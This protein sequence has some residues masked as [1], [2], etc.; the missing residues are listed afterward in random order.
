MKK[1]LSV[2]LVLSLM[3][4]A[5]WLVSCGD[6]KE[7]SAKT[8]AENTP[9]ETPDTT[10]DENKEET[11]DQ[12]VEEPT[13]PDVIT[14]DEQV[15]YD[16]DGVVIT[17]KG[18]AED[19]LFGTTLKLLIENNSDK[20]ISVGVDSMILNGFEM[21]PLFAE[22]VA[23]G[24]KANAEL[25]LSFEELEK[26]GIKT[27]GLIELV[28]EIYDPE[29]YDTYALSDL[30]AV[31]TNAYEVM[32]TEITAEGTELYNANGIKVVTLGM[33]DTILGKSI[34]LYIENTSDKN[35]TLG[36]DS[37]SLNGFMIEPLF[38]EDV[39]AGKKVI[40]S[41][42]IA[43][44]DLEDNGIE[45]IENIEFVLSITDAETWETIATSDP[46]VLGME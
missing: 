19:I 11:P 12:K 43:T 39:S 16:N 18:L 29:T 6:N 30:V 41:I 31:K 24:K 40:G 8:P 22:D 45:N 46:I 17:A 36:T 21:F 10:P 44:S 27:L 33:E 5:F 26:V 13:V 34:C 1:L 35:V 25:T 32:D 15:I 42:D 3:T 28:F 20:N 14:V 23:A 38:Y 37:F 9:V 2:I 4:A 7:E